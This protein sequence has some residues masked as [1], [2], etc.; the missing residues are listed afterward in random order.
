MSLAGI[1]TSV[2]SPHSTRAASVSAACRSSV[3]IQ[4][5]LKT[6]GWSSTFY[7]VKFYNKPIASTSE[8]ARSMLSDFLNKQTYFLELKIVVLYCLLCFMGMYL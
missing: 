8:Y 7:F 5:I 2:Y 6:A 3:K 4:D 1:D